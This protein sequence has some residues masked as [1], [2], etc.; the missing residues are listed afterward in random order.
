MCWNKEVSITTFALAMIG[1]IYLFRRNKPNDRWIAVFA[2]T[3][4]MIQLA[5]FFMWSDLD[6]G[7]MNMYASMFAL[8]I[9]ALEPMMNMVGGIYFSN[10]P[11]KNVLRYMLLAYFV[12]IAFFYFTQMRNKETTW[13]GTTA[14]PTTSN[15][16]AGFGQSKS[17][18]LE[19]YFLHNKDGKLG[20][21]WIL[22]LMLP[23]LA[24]T[25]TTQGIT[26]FALGFATFFAA[27]LLNN[28]AVGSMWCWLSILIIFVKIL[29]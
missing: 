16:L 9:L 7:K 5:E 6:C 22:F 20:I 24:M 26:F 27:R 2:A 18:N 8:L 4:G 3:I 11:Y 19:W 23:F 15:P 28:A 1:A 12:F 13:C 17:C 29:M 10:S 14:C 21:I 25:P